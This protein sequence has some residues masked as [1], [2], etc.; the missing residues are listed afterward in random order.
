MLNELQA[1][2]LVTNAEKTA[3]GHKVNALLEKP[4]IATLFSGEKYVK[5]EPDLLLTTGEVLRPHRLVT[6]EERAI[7]LDFRAGKPSKKDRTKMEQYEAALRAMGY[8]S[9]EKLILNTETEQIEPLS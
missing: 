4:D 1:R 9:V 8:A 2:G 6:R 5:R 7:V 3:V